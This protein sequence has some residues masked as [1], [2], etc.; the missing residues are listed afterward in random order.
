MSDV[1]EN[2]NGDNGDEKAP[3]TLREQNSKLAQTNAELQDQLK[4]LLAKDRARTIADVLRDKGANPKIAKYAERELPDGNVDASAVEKWLTDEGEL[5][6]Y[7]P[8]DADAGDGSGDE[9][10]ADEAV[11]QQQ[12]RISA[13]SASAPQTPTGWT[14]EKI[15]NATSQ[16]LIEAGLLDPK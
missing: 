7:K 13:A 12:Q 11:V 4:Q 10:E 16:Q 1:D 5:F 3:K 8:A 6:G 14:P 9:D 2:D 15:R